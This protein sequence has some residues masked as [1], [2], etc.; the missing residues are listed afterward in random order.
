MEKL[1]VLIELGL[2][3]SAHFERNMVELVN[4]HCKFNIKKSD[5]IVSIKD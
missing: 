5:I 1:G 3:E 2:K 4:S